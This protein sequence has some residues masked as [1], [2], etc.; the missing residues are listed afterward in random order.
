MTELIASIH[1]QASRDIRE[2]EKLLVQYRDN[3]LELNRLLGK[4]E[5][6]KLGRDRAICALL[7]AA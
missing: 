7:E 1:K 4:I 5:G 2:L 6:V 3:P